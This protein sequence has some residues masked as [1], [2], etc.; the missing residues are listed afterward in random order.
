LPL[1]A[2]PPLESRERRNLERRGIDLRTNEAARATLAELGVPADDDEPDDR[3]F[4][5]SQ[6]VAQSVFDLLETPDDYEVVALSRQANDI[7]KNLLGYDVGYW[8]GDFFSLICDTIVAPRWHPPDPSD[9]EEVAE[10]LRGLNNHLLFTGHDD[11]LAF[12]KYYM[13]KDWA[14]Q[15]LQADQFRIIAVGTA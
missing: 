6:A 9:F 15:E 12:R 2:M 11:A 4:L 10:R 7:P 3:S 13:S 1:E 8:G 14:E 5:P